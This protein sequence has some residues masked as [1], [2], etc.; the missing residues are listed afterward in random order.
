MK[1]LIMLLALPLT[2]AAEDS[3]VKVPRYVYECQ[4]WDKQILTWCDKWVWVINPAFVED[5]NAGKFEYPLGEDI[6]K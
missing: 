3:P 5:P 2:M 4:Q 1:T 6:I